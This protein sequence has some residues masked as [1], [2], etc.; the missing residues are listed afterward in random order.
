MANLARPDHSKTRVLVFSANQAD[1]PLDID[2]EVA[3][4]SD[5]LRPAGP[6]C[7]VDYSPATRPDR[8]VAEMGRI[9]PTIVHFIGHGSPQGIELLSEAGVRPASGPALRSLFTGRGVHLVVLS[10]CFSAEQAAAIQPEV[11]AVVGTS[12][13]LDDLAGPSFGAAFYAALARG[14]TVGD[15]VRDGRAA[16]GLNDYEGDFAVWGDR[17]LR[18]ITE[19][20]PHGSESGSGQGSWDTPTSIRV[21]A[22]ILAI[23]L[24]WAGLTLI[25]AGDDGTGGGPQT[26]PTSVSLP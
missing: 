20:G 4:I 26:V 25:T 17:T 10:C 8:M 7:R 3:A 19:G 6:G 11:G 16:V 9:D 1:R 5:A 23:V 24:A 21:L 14:E 13:R 15:A 22:L 2:L 18:L 12:G